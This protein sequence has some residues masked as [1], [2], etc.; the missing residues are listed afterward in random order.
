MTSFLSASSLLLSCLAAL[1]S[2]S[3]I[4]VIG[5]GFGRTG[6]T[7]LH[8]ALGILG[9]KTYHMKE[10]V[11]SGRMSDADYWMD[12][13]TAPKKCGNP[14][15]LRDL[16]AS[17]GYTASA[18]SIHHVCLEEMIFDLYPDAKVIH[19]ERNDADQWHDSVANS[20]CMAGTK[21]FY[22]IKVLGL[23]VPAVRFIGRF[24]PHLFGTVFLGGDYPLTDGNYQTK[25]FCLARKEEMVSRY[26]AHNAWVKA[27][28]PADRLLVITNHREGW[29][30]ICAFLG[31]EVPPIPFPHVNKRE[32]MVREMTT[33]ILNQN[34]TVT[35]YAKVV[36]GLAILGFLFR[37]AFLLQRSRS[38]TQLQPGAKE[39]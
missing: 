20:L 11:T 17:G 27:T 24:V 10:I 4:R 39:D 18:H 30:P 29:G 15:G 37:M 1:A 22:L 5:T 7:T 25:E 6:S 21:K 28:V 3:E 32:S 26:E 23:F 19:T 8:E 31:E 2:A 9:H 38:K 33:K 34:P 12:A 35:T 13:Y 14:A 16:F 36:G